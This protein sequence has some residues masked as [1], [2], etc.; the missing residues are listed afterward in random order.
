MSDTNIATPHPHIN[1][2]A[3]DS[4]ETWNHAPLTSDDL[5][6]V[7]L[8]LGHTEIPQ[9]QRSRPSL[10]EA[11]IDTGKGVKGHLVVSY[12]NEEKQVTSTA[13]ARPIALTT[14]TAPSPTKTSKESIFTRIAKSIGIKRHNTG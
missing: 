7:P 12:A 4:L 13:P 2:P 10:D 14:T 1:S 9:V 5:P 3:E 8:G 11:S 6:V